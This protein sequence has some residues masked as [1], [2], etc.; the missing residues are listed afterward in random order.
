[1]RPTKRA[2]DW[3]D[4][5]R[6]TS[7]FLASGFSCFQTFSQPARQPLTQTVGHR[8]IWNSKSK[9]VSLAVVFAPLFGFGF[10]GSSSHVWFARLNLY[11]MLV[12]CSANHEARCFASRRFLVMSVCWRCRQSFSLYG[13]RAGQIV[14]V[15]VAVRGSQSFVMVLVFMFHV[16]L[17]ES[18]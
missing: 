10:L 8:V 1:M 13:F 17:P 14:S 16:V 3:R 5:V 18:R 6:F 12:G 9:I 4:S 15:F 11:V 2:V 7:I